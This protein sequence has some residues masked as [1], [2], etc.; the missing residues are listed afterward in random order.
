MGQ[1]KRSRCW[2]L[3]VPGVVVQWFHFL[4]LRHSRISFFLCPL[5]ETEVLPQ[6]P[7]FAIDSSRFKMFNRLSICLPLLLVPN[8]VEGWITQPPTR[9]RPATNLGAEGGFSEGLNTV[10]NGGKGSSS[11][12]CKAKELVK[13]LLE[14]ERC[15]ATDSGALA[16]G[17]ACAV[18]VV[19]EDCFEPQPFVGRAVR[20]FLRECEPVGTIT[21]PVLTSLFFVERDESHES[22]SGKAKGSRRCSN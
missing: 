17:E 4:R 5:A 18:N 14:E 19:Y 20:N 12:F 13:E 10:S 11:R 8:L 1:R 9:T 7:P 22:Q 15:F 16:F 2:L 6:T 3:Q 21:L